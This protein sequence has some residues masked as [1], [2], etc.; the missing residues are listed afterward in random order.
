MRPI[1][2]RSNY[3]LVTLGFQPFSY[4]QCI[5]STAQEIGVHRSILICLVEDSHDL[6]AAR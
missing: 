5:L 4:A 1:F 2:V 6:L 3:V